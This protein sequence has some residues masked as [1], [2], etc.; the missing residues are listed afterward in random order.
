[1]DYNKLLKNFI[2]GRKLSD[3]E[4]TLKDC[5]LSDITITLHDCIDLNNPNFPSEAHAIMNS[6]LIQKGLDVNIKHAGNTA[7]LTVAQNC[8]NASCI[9]T[10]MAIELIKAGADVNVLDA[11]GESALFHCFKA[12]VQPLLIQTLIDNGADLNLRVPNNGEYISPVPEISIL[13]AAYWNGKSFFNQLV[14]KGATM[15][16]EEI[17]YLKSINRPL[18]VS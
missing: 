8:H 16:D 2:K 15:T 14:E 4:N 11:E 9:Y 13:A 7:L 3:F 12:N 18:S 5:Q 10:V 6:Q 1:M 17:D